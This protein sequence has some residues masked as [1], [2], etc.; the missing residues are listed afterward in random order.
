MNLSDGDGDALASALLSES[1][2]TMPYI[3]YQTKKGVCKKKERKKGVCK[4]KERKMP[5]TVC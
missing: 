4:K 5:R 1:E 3:V 2:E